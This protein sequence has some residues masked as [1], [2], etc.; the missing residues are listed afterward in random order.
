LEYRNVGTS[1]LQVSVVGLGCNNFGSRV[2][3]AGTEKIVHKALDLGVT[4]F[5]TADVYGALWVQGGREGLSEEYLGAALGPHRRDVVIATKSN[6]PM[7]DGPYWGGASRRYLMD[8]VE[9]CLRR[10]NT[11]YIDLYI[12]HRWD[13]LTPIEETLR[14]LDDMVR[15]GKVRYIGCSM[16]AA[17]QLVESLW[18][19]DVWGVERFACVLREYNLISRAVEADLLPVCQKY[20]VGLVPL[21]PLANGLLTGKYRRGEPPPPDSRLA[22]ERGAHYRE[23][24][25]SEKNF[26]T[27]ARLE[28]LGNRTGH[29]LLEMAIG[30]LKAK[31][32]IP[33]VIAGVTSPEQV[34]AN[35]AASEARFTK[36]EMD[37]IS[38]ILDS[39]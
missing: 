15:S 2:D 18:K 33:S 36:E 7:G 35:V 39:A 16:Y 11:D 3:A 21:F 20:G 5:D 26:A 12:M 14:A 30:W 31:T 37:E 22:T 17:W 9:A 1:G 28:D 6:V 13:P 34:E 8:A 4:F 29:T 19:S 27:I 10:L 25:M 23:T 32:I 24:L 38:S